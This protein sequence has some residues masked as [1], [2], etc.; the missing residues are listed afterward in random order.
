MVWLIGN[1][2]WNNVLG[3][4]ARVNEWFHLDFK[5]YTYIRNASIWVVLLVALLATDDESIAFSCN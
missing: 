1:Y 3:K 4:F 2:A 5:A